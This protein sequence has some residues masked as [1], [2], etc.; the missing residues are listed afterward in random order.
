MVFCP[1]QNID[2]LEGAHPIAA[3]LR[4]VFC[5]IQFAPVKCARLEEL[6][7]PPAVSIEPCA[8]SFV[9]VTWGVGQIVAG[10]LISG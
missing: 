8:S 10:M 2:F 7:P 5:P 3:E 1:L 4:V 6:S 9:V